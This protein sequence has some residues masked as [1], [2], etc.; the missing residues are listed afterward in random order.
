MFSDVTRDSI[1]GSNFNKQ[2]RGFIQGNKNEVSNIINSL[3]GWNELTISPK[4]IVNYM[5]CHDDFTL[6]DKLS[7]T[8]Q[9][10]EDR[11]KEYK[12]GSAIMFSCQGNLFF[13]SGEEFCRT[14]GGRH[15][16]YNLPID[17]NKLDWNR[18]YKYNDIYKYY[19][20]LIGLRKQILGLCDKSKRAF[21]RFFDIWENDCCISFSLNNEDTTGSW[22]FIKFIFNANRYPVK[23]EL[24]PYKYQVLVNDKSSNLWKENIFIEKSV[25]VPPISAMILAYN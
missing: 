11:I 4:Q 2:A 24:K 19:E 1:K 25:E 16:T 15:N 20:G 6:W 10:T 18:A 3:K 14:K 17:I 9:N 22:K 12:L 8:T 13:L 5:S 7:I 23:L 21:E